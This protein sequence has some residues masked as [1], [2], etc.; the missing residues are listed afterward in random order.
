MRSGVLADRAA[1]KRALEL[2]EAASAAFAALPLDALT[3]T[4]LLA[5]AD[6]REAMRRAQA[7]VD[8]RLYGRLANE[9]DPREFGAK[10][11]TEV[12][13]LRLRISRIDARNRIAVA[14]DLAPRTAM[15][16][17]VLQPVLPT[18]AT[19][20]AAGEIGT[21]HVSVIR[22][23]FKQL[24]AS[25]DATTRGQAEQDVAR[26][27]RELGPDEL[28]QV[29]TK[30]ASLLDQ[31]GTL[32]DGDRARRRGITIGRQQFD[33]MS[34]ITGLLDPE[35][36]ATLD[37]VF[38]KLAA[39]GMCN[40][41]ETSPR[42]DGSAS[43]QQ[44]DADLRSPAQRRHDALTALSRA[45]LASGDL[46][47]HRG[48]PATIFIST[49]LAEL[50]SATGHAVTAGG[51]LLPMS[52][53]IRQARH[54]HHYL[55]VFDD[56]TEVPLYLGRSKRIASAG[57]RIVLYGR[58]RGCT[59]PGCT[60]PAY[61]CEVHHAVTDWAD[62]GQTNIDELTLACGRH[63]QLIGPDG[64][65]TRKREDGR[66]EWILP[67]ELDSGGARTNDYHH[68]ERLLGGRDRD[69]GEDDDHH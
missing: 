30:L 56:A 2:H 19:G 51:T 33:G 37:A 26:Y 22:S 17:E 34:P 27:A 63:H 55:A 54:A 14:Q 64:W 48:L 60:V 44:I 6:R 45:M 16:G 53:V 39:P 5:V 49:T 66:T 24:P 67:A 50:E 28:R 15:T 13:A 38:A 29:A 7:A 31:D 23:F 1:I 68:P 46:G 35:L 47:Q 62:E 58:E 65:Q 3:P 9:C 4:D 36:R 25:V 8:H 43:Q 69:D 41:D 59:A 57:Q 21:E 11:M 10:S 20:V 52:D 18:V 42:V 61:Y 32:T 40:P 12:L